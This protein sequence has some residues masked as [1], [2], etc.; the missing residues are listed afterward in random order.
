MANE[1]I[2]VSHDAY[3]IL[4]YRDW[5]WLQNVAEEHHGRQLHGRILHVWRWGAVLY[6][7]IQHWQEAASDKIKWAEK[8]GTK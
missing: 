4:K 1:E 8:I 7:A 3:Q 5:Q 2:F 6:K